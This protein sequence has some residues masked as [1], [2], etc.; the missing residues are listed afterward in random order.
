[1]GMFSGLFKKKNTIN[2]G[3]IPTEENNNQS[4]SLNVSSAEFLDDITF[5]QD[6]KHIEAKP[7]HQYDVLLAAKIYGWD[8]MIDWADYIAQADLDHITEVKTASNIGVKDKD[9]TDSYSKH[10]GKCAQTPELKTEMGVLSIAGIS[11][12]LKAPLKIVWVNQTR[13]LRLFTLNGDELYIKKY[14]ET[15]V[16]RTFGTENEMKLGKPIPEES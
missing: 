9:I 6:V 16:R 10:G 8:M 4:A 3:N 13:V 1:M 15:M 11:K 14:I 2:T 5:I 12:K 7:W